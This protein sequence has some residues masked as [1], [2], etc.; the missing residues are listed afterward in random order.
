[1]I[2]KHFG[3]CGGCRFQNTPYSEQLKNKEARV[4]ELMLASGLCA[5]LKPINAYSE[6]FYRN[7]MEFTFS[8]EPMACGFGYRKPNHGPLACG[9]YNNAL[10]RSEKKVIDI[11]E[12]LISCEY[13]GEIIQKIK[14]L[15][16][17]EKYPA[18]NKFSYQGL[19]RHLIIRESKF[20]GD[21]MLGVVTT[22]RLKFDKEAFLKEI[23]SLPFSGK[24]KS[25][26]WIINDSMSDAVVFEK[27]ELLYGEPFIIEKLDGLS[28]RI[29]IDT[30]FQVNPAA[31]KDLYAKIRGY[32][33]L[34]QDESVLDLFCG[35]GGIGMALAPDA[36]FVWGVELHETIVKAARENAV[37]NNLN[38]ISFFASDVRKFLNTQSAFHKNIELVVINPPRA[39][40]SNK[41]IRAVLRLS[42]KRIIYSSCNPETLL[43][44]L[45]DLRKSYK[46]EFIEPFDFFPH[47]P[48]MECLAV[49]KR[50]NMITE[51]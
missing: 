33:V 20:S 30:F 49:L 35:A 14:N 27:K 51:I 16:L 4:K 8:G 42:P 24:I 25:I 19:L 15:A 26:Y 23:L 5:E 17:K 38:N 41:I 47:T 39:G 31:I 44:D 12:C 36:K 45:A 43:R 13:A 37:L 29:G 46:L 9:L 10:K 11:E 21:L 18:Y 48:H 3:S 34:S 28:F 2:C 1:M 32:S 6:W 22:S 50:I 40:L 7:K